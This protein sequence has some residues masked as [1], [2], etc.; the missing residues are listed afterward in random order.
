[1]ITRA[2]SGPAYCSAE[3]DGGEMLTGASISAMDDGICKDDGF[4]KAH[5]PD[6]GDGYGVKP[7][8]AAKQD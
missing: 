2:F 4:S 8:L 5:H 3:S 1:M 6:A 7:V